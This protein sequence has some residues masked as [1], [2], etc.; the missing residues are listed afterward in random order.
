M[1]FDPRWV[2]RKRSM[3]RYARENGIEVPKGIRFTPSCGAA[4][5]ALIRNIERKAFGAD[6]VTGKWSNALGTLVKREAPLR[7][8][9]YLVAEK[10]IGVKEDPPNSNDGLRIREYQK[11]TGAFKAPWCASFVTWC[12]KQAGKN[13]SGFNTAYCPSWV[14]AARANRNGLRVISRDDA[15][16]GDAVLYDWGRDG[17]S[18]HIGVLA[19][20]IGDNGDF[21][22]VEGNTSYGNDS[23]GGQVML[24]RRNTKDVLLFVRVGS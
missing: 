14:E 5:E 9:A 17:V 18:D 4:C 6:R 8:K 19:G 3:V 7:E 10:E 13:L 12:Y 15:R 1:G 2:S 16:R 22:A 21:I 11:V 20:R 23:N 24:R